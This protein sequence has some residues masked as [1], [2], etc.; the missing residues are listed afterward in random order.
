VINSGFHSFYCRVRINKKG[1]IIVDATP[2]RFY[3]NYGYKMVGHKEIEVFE[4]EVV[5]DE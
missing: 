3:K 1:E 5:K 4:P 2:H